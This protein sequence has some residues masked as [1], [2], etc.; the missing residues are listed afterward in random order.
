MSIPKFRVTGQPYT[1]IN[2]IYFVQTKSSPVLHHSPGLETV[3]NITGSD[4]DDF[5]RGVG[6]TNHLQDGDGKDIIE[7]N[8][9]NDVLEW[10][11]AQISYNLMAM[12]TI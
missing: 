3:E 8:Y 4:H 5:L 12:L 7:A 10:G 6:D 2:I 1:F 9:G 11:V